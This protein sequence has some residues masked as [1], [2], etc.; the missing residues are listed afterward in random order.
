MD[1]FT[2]RPAVDVDVVQI[3]EAIQS[4]TPLPIPEMSPGHNVDSGIASIDP[5]DATISDEFPCPDGD[6]NAPEDQIRCV[7]T[8]DHD[9]VGPFDPYPAEIPINIQIMSRTLRTNRCFDLITTEISSLKS[10]SSGLLCLLRHFSVG[11]FTPTAQNS[12]WYRPNDCHS[13]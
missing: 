2:I 13:G 3:L 6:F 10:P 5:S 11:Y 8:L 1:D 4:S 12:Y 7:P 9:A